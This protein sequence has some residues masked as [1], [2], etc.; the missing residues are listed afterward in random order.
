MENT[1]K[2]IRITDYNN[3]NKSLETY[4]ID[5]TELPMTNITNEFVTTK[6]VITQ[7]YD[8]LSGLKGAYNGLDSVNDAKTD[9]RMKKI[10][11]LKM[12][13]MVPDPATGKYVVDN[14]KYKSL[15]ERD[16]E[17]E[18]SK[19]GILAFG[20]K[21][22]LQ[23]ITGRNDIAFLATGEI[24]KSYYKGSTVDFPLTSFKV[25]LLNDENSTSI[26]K[27]DLVNYFSLPR[28]FKSQEEISEVSESFG[29]FTDVLDVIGGGI[30]TFTKTWNTILGSTQSNS[31]DT[32]FNETQ[33]YLSNSLNGNNQE[34]FQDVPPW[35]ILEIDGVMVFDKPPLIVKSINIEFSEEF[36]NINGE[37]LPQYIIATFT[38]DFI[39]IPTYS[40]FLT[41]HLL[42]KDFTVKID[43]ALDTLLKLDKESSEELMYNNPVEISDCVPVNRN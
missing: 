9:E 22:A 36:E 1:Y 5:Y 12:Q 6:D 32:G 41:A 4:L 40:E 26:Q 30:G 35:L 25:A 16:K 42:F 7:T 14:K 34:T 37:L 39:Q 23:S 18:R 20:K 31:P 3:P 33:G 29:T 24:T 21:I 15:L 8:T 19:N 10:E 38:L 17:L 43:E 2:K 27:L 13:A 28:L 11:D